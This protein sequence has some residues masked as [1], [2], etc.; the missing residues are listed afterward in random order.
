MNDD[1]FD[2]HGWLEWI[3]NA[4]PEAKDIRIEGKYDGF[5]TLVIVRMP[6]PV[7]NLLP[8]DPAYSFVGFIMS[9]NYAASP[10]PDTPLPC[11]ERCVCDSCAACE[12]STIEPLGQKSNIDTIQTQ[13]SEAILEASPKSY[14]DQEKGKGRQALD[15]SLQRQQLKK[16]QSSSKTL[17]NWHQPLSL[18]SQKTRSILQP[19][20]DFYSTLFRQ[21]APDSIILK[22]EVSR[23]LGG[24][25]ERILIPESFV[26]SGDNTNSPSSASRMPLSHSQRACSGLGSTS[27]SLKTPTNTISSN[28]DNIAG[29]SNIRSNSRRSRPNPSPSM[30]R[31]P[32]DTSNSLRPRTSPVREAESEALDSINGATYE[33][34]HD[35]KNHFLVWYC[36]SSLILYRL[37]NCA[38]MINRAGVELDR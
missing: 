13:C 32:S 6:I 18:R 20:K 26:L 21:D 37:P 29:P 4:P 25:D 7:W 9:E 8:E 23:E 24:D 28:A 30:G 35:G 34:V 17:K 3:R 15:E 12:S 19:F 33:R 36:V 27:T 5:S 38:L 22:G 16:D 10:I 31:S 14:H 2:S 11:P 1:K